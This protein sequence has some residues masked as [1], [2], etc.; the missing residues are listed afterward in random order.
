MDVSDED[1]MLQLDGLVEGVTPLTQARDNAMPDVE[2]QPEGEKLL[3]D[4]L[5]LGL[6]QDL[7]SQQQEEQQQQE[8]HQQEEQ[9]QEQHN[10]Y[11]NHDVE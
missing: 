9:Q 3:A 1:F 10:Y 2:H 4:D 11:I 8:Q 5:E 6:D 7:E